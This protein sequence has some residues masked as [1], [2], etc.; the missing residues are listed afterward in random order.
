MNW[1]YKNSTADNINVFPENTVGF[2][3]ELTLSDGKKYIGKKNIK[4][5][6]K[7]H[8]TKKELALVTDK[9][10][11]TYKYIT[12]ES[13]W[14]TYNGSSEL[15]KVKPENVTIT[16]KEILEVG[17]SKKHL[18][19]LEA[20]YLFCKEV[21]ESDDYYNINILGKFFKKDIDDAIHG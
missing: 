14:K 13:D 17:F 6:R 10:L 1:I 9:R 15:L 20:K 7:K 19:Y 12:A 3:Y 5:V 8:F 4:S 18:T 11:K 21:I 16:N 2:V